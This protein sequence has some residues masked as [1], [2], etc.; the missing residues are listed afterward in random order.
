MVEV[1][2]EVSVQYILDYNVQREEDREIGRDQLEFLD[3]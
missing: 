1:Q 2:F 3:F